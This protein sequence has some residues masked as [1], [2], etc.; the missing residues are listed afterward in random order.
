MVKKFV[1]NWYLIS[2]FIAGVY[3]LILYFGDWN[4]RE[5]MLLASSIFI[6]LHFFEEFAFPGGFPWVGMKVELG[7]KDNDP[8]DWPLN[9]L[10]AMFGNWWF[11]VFVYLLPLFLPDVRF[12]TLAAALFAFLEVL[13]HLFFFNISLKTWYNPGLFTAVF[14]LMP[15]SLFYFYQVW[16]QHLYGWPDILLAVVWMGFNYWMGFR[17]P[18]YKTL[19]KKNGQWA[20]TQDE[21]ER[22]GY[23]KKFHDGDHQ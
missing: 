19:G 13:M 4:I 21:V 23:L 22:A 2:V 20:F 11:A 10:N 7:I 5:K 6:F 14:G 17:S 12:L 3:A 1:K 18:V 15:V 16:D 9:E 8:K